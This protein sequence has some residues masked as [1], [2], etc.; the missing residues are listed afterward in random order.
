M[1]YPYRGSVYLLTVDIAPDTR[2]LAFVAFTDDRIAGT[3]A[4]SYID[5]VPA[6]TALGASNLR[7]RRRHPAQRY[8]GDWCKADENRC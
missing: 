5:A 8:D 2:E 3:R 1:V 4:G 7:I 6:A